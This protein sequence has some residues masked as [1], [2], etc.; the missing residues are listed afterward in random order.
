MS[1]EQNMFKT[2]FILIVAAAM[3]CG[4][5]HADTP[6]T[7]RLTLAPAKV[8]PGLPTAFLV[9]ITNP[10]NQQ[11][12]VYDAGMLSV[13]AAGTGF[14]AEVNGR[15]ELN[16]PHEQM[17]KCNDSYCLHVPP[18]ST[19]ELY[20]DFT[21]SL[22]GNPYFLDA[23]LNVSGTYGLKLTL[24]ATASDGSET[25]LSTQTATLTI[26]QP[27]GV[28]AD[29]W[30]WLTQQTGAS[31]SVMEWALRGNAIAAQLRARFPNS[32]YVA[33]VAAL[34]AAT[35]QEQL[36]N[37]DAALG[38][39]PPVGLRDALLFAKG[40]LLAESNGIAIY[41]LRDLQSALT[42][43]EAATTTL[44]L[45]RDSAISSCMRQQAAGIINKLYTTRTGQVTL[46][47]LA[48][49]DPPAPLQVVPRVECV[50]RGTGQS[51]SARF[52][53]SNPNRALKVIALG[54][55]NQITPA[56]RDQGQPRAFKPGDHPNVFTASSPG[57]E[58][59]WHLDGSQAV[60]SADFPVQCTAQP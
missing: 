3:V 31:F 54:D 37:I 5:I 40:S 35:R 47:Q 6:L 4:Q 23:R 60:A 14:D 2:K 57:G 41:S 59:K 21:P 19:K 56:P 49:L 58:L 33:W 52:G 48:A 44:T 18:L 24:R 38:A 12:Q 16:L 42:Y 29:V 34:G 28:D 17:E 25:D 27:E 8:L 13:A 39:N 9:S 43:S 20:F 53:Y 50:S 36:A 7:A 51:F 26:E 46:R 30:T 55:D 11:Q 1:L 10:S 45:L 15:T 32:R 22:A